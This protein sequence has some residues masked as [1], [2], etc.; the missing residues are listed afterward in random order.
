M[1]VRLRGECEGESLV[2]SWGECLSNIHPSRLPEFIGTLKNRGVVWLFVLPN[3]E[4]FAACLGRK[5]SQPGKKIF[6]RWENNI[7]TL[8][9][10][11]TINSVN[12]NL[13]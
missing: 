6:P 5:C 12:A 1:R 9:I 3:Q 7:P 13:V 8:G 10:I 4:I 2:R 11:A